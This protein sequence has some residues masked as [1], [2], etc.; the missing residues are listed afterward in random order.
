[1]TT[2]L[3]SWIWLAVSAQESASLWTSCATTENPAPA[4]PAR[5]ASTEALI[6]M[7]SVEEEMDRMS[8]VRAPMRSTLRLFSMA[9]SRTAMISSVRVRTS[10]ISAWAERSISSARSRIPVE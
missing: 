1:M 5:V 7:R 2:P 8:L 3:T 9:R 4:A 10:S 6:A